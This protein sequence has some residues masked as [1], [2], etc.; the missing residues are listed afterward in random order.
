MTKLDWD[1][2]KSRPERE[3]PAIQPLWWW[4]IG[5]NMCTDCRERIEPGNPYAFNRSERRVLCLR[6]VSQ[7]GVEPA[8]SRRYRAW[9]NQR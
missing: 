1:K 7:L 4:T 3:E 9:E 2:A 6:C 8:K 5:R